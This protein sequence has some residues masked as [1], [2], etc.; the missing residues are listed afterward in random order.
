MRV[1]TAGRALVP[2]TIGAA[3]LA[4]VP[5]PA[6]AAPSGPDY[7]MPFPCGDR[8]NGASR[9]NHSP[10]ADAIDWNRINDLGAM[11]VSAAP[12]VVTS[13]VDLGDR[14]YGRYI[15]VDHGGGHSTLYAHLSAFWSTP[16]QAVDQGTPIGLVGTSGGSTGPHLHFEQRLNR[17][18]QRAYFHRLP[19]VMNTTLDSRNCSDAPVVG[20]W[21]GN[22][23]ANVGVQRRSTT[24]TYFLRRPGERAQRIPFGWRTDQAV[25]GDW[26]GDGRDEIGVRRPGLRI[27]ELR[28]GDGS[29]RTVPLGRVSDFGVTG[30]WD[31]D[32]TTDLGVWNPGTR[33]FTLRAADGSRTRVPLGAPGDRPVTGDWDGDR[34]ADLGVWSASTATFTLRTVRSS[35]AVVLH[36]V[37]FGSPTS[38][39]VTGDWNGD[40]VTDLGVWGTETGS[41]ALRVSRSG[42][43]TDVAVRRVRWGRPRG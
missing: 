26:D 9:Y 1:W 5:G 29:T 21:D 42:S 8:W 32:G 18:D 12:G 3:L 30:D 33:A 41:F 10:S 27:F 15:V 23:T 6:G 16:G 22:G 43:P 25:S 11:T 36:S 31:G 14:S 7:E 2:L 35:G 24:P 20:D 40:G 37:R 13:V 34:R 38:L 4:G 39:P 17:R 19:F 28:S